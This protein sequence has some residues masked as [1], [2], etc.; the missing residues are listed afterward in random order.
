MNM[1]NTMKKGT[2]W[3]LAAVLAGGLA[4]CAGDGY[5]VSGTVAPN[6]T[7]MTLRVLDALTQ[8]VIDSAVHVSAGAFRMEGQADT[9]RLATLADGDGPMMLFVLENGDISL[10]LD[11]TD[12][13][14]S[15]ASGTPLNDDFAAY[16]ERVERIFSDPAASDEEAQMKQL[17]DLLNEIVERHADDVVGY[18]WFMNAAN[19][20]PDSQ[21]LALAR[22]MEPRWKGDRRFA[23]FVAAYDR[24]AATRPGQPFTDFAVENDGATT[25]LSD[26]VGRGQYALVDFWASWCGPC[27]GE[28]PNLIEAYNTYR[29]EGLVVLGVAT[30][31]K[32]ADTQRAIEELGIP[33]PQI[34]NAQRI[35]SDAYGIQGIPEIILFAPDGTILERGLRGAAIGEK[36]RAIYGK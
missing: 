10:T 25:R 33:Y 28:I 7:T 24:K 11:Y 31:D 34:L 2:M 15:K 22:R 26:Y 5:R 23:E 14:K 32:V 8:E 35:G 4:A 18:Y 3:A 27:R 16:G 36:L 1:T 6:D 21:A 29:G 17:G 19:V 30:W 12:P 13:T 9:A 20:L